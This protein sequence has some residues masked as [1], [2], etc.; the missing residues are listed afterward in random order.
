MEPKPKRAKVQITIEWTLVD[1]DDYPIE[2]VQSWRE[3]AKYDVE[4]IDVDAPF[5][6][7]ITATSEPE[8]VDESEFEPFVRSEDSDRDS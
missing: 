7:I 6:A 2:V 1:P 8:L 3:A 4:M 5:S